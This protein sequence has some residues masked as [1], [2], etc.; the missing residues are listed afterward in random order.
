LL[1][2]VNLS[3]PCA[4]LQEKLSE[5]VYLRYGVMAVFHAGAGSIGII[6]MPEV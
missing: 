3:P 2:S 1:L 5:I 4:Y 6:L